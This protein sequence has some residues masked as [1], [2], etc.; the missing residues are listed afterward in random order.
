MNSASLCSLAGRYDNPVPPRFLT[1]IGS[2]KI[3][4]LKTKSTLVFLL[5]GAAYT[6]KKSKSSKLS[7]L[8]S[9]QNKICTVAVP[10]KRDVSISYIVLISAQRW[11]PDWR[12]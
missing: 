6:H 9:K 5:A 7:K 8:L 12:D 11:V 2:I 1:P 4:A 3:P 10:L